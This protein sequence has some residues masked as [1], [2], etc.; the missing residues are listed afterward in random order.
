MSKQTVLEGKP[1]LLLFTGA[2]FSA[3]AGAPVMKD[4]LAKAAATLP[5][6][7]VQPVRAGFYFTGYAMREEPNL[8]AAYGAMIFRQVLHGK[9]LSKQKSQPMGKA[10]TVID[11]NLNIAQGVCERFRRYQTVLSAVPR[12][13]RF[14]QVRGE[15]E[16]K[17][18]A[19]SW[20]PD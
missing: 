4:F 19:P 10:V 3:D 17:G 8:E 16:R 20:L 1:L 13:L 12:G 5:P 11:S 14:D 18:I 6:K 9:P 15:L 7:M 2:G